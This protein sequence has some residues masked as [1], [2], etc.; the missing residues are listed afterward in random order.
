MVFTWWFIVVGAV[1]L[2]MALSSSLLARLPL[3]TAMFYL[4]AGI[5]IGPHALALITIDPID[6]AEMIERVTEVAVIISLFSAGL[7]L[8]LPRRDPFR[9]L[10]VILASW[11]MLLTV[12]LITIV[13]TLALDLPLG[14]A[15]L[16]G[17]VLAPTDPVL[18][19][20]VQVTGPRDRDRLR[21]TLTGEAG[22]NDGTA[23]PFV[24]LGL[25]LLGLGDLGTFGWRWFVIDGVWPIT[26]GYLSA[27]CWG[28][29]PVA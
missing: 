16:L 4:G 6:H 15:V 9:R 27:R 13:G 5:L 20:D 11:S 19:S 17:A 14:A 8:Q 7:K 3:S 28:P 22:L 25:G 24:L 1:F 29:R 2:L 18:A 12:G 26:G 23:F 10:P 21:F